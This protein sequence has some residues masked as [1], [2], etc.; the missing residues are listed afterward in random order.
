MIIN[1]AALTHYS[2]ALHDAIKA[3]GMPAVEVHLSDIQNR[4]AFRKISVT[5]PACIT[6]ISGKG[7]M[8]YLEGMATL[9]KHLGGGGKK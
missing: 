7:R 9:I 1:P 3:V 2:F 8:S 6:Q 4:E 5:A